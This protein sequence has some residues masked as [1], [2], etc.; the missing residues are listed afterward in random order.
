MSSVIC[1]LLVYLFVF[2]LDIYI[3]VFAVLL[4]VFFESWWFDRE[5]RQW[6]SGQTDQ[7]PGGSTIQENH[8]YY[9]IIKKL[10]L[11][12]ETK[13]KRTRSKEKQEVMVET[14]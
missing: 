6:G 3:F 13:N 8:K 4:T 12:D 10:D 1:L 5:Y 11:E 14:I 2:V 9:R 7:P